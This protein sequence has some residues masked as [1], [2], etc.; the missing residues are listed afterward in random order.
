MSVWDV[1]A[2][3]LHK[4]FFGP[5]GY[6]AL[7][8]AIDPADPNVMVGQGCEWRID[9]KTGR[10]ACLGTI[11]RDGMEVSRFATG[12][13][14]KTYLA[15]TP[16]WAFNTAP[17]RI[18][19][20][21]GDADYKL[22]TVVTY[23]DKAG[24]ELGAGGHGQKLPVAQTIVW[25]DENGDGVRQ[26]GETVSR[27]DGELRFSGWYMSLTPEMAIYSKDLQFKLAGFTA[28]GA[29]KYDL[30]RPMKMPAA[31][32][33][34]ADGRFVLAGGEYAASHAWMTCYDIAS[35]KALWKYPDTFVGVHG[36]HNAPP[37][38]PGLVRGSFNPC[39]S[40]KLPEPVGN[41]WVIPTNVGEWHVLT[42]GGYYL[43]GLFQGDPLK[44][45]WPERATPG[46]A[47]DGV[48]PGMGGEDFGGSATLALDGKLYL[49]AGKTAYWNV[50]VTGLETV[51]ALAGG[52]VRIAEPLTKQAA[53]LREQYLQAATA[54]RS[55]TIRKGTPTF[56]GDLSKDFGGAKCCSSPSSRT[57]PS[58]PPPRG[59]RRPSTWRGT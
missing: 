1:K 13:N 29:P 41:V 23:L 7:G 19:E 34:S 10:A 57:P 55:L 28:R 21:V 31:G 5:S 26:E 48:P 43:T 30:S 38:E 52:S 4:E 56:T 58:A 45:R 20:R 24:N 42:E 39:G 12:P 37:G 2:D 6:G 50:E 44:V 32:F 35:G 27:A 3:A 51:K 36:S 18:Y 22:R 59:T 54:G 9:P 49:Q 8:G 16:G 47:M 17:L 46:A 11:T 33:G 40:V 53:A 15:V 14:G 25:T